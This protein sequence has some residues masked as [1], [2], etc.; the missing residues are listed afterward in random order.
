MVKKK[1]MYL[2]IQCKQTD[3]PEVSLYAASASASLAIANKT[4]NKKNIITNGN[5]EDN[6]G[7]IEKQTIEY[8]NN[9]DAE[10]TCM[11]TE[12]EYNEYADRAELSYVESDDSDLA[13]DLTK[14][15][16]Y[17]DAPDTIVINRI[18]TNAN[19]V[20]VIE[21]GKRNYSSYETEY[22]PFEICT[23]STNVKNT[24]NAKG[25]RITADYIIEI[26][27]AVA[28]KSHLDIRARI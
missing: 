13:G 8:A 17:K 23:Y 6:A 9:T 27:G 2:D 25:G 4:F 28:E 5:E 24:M 26:K 22:M 12:A 1:K 19:T 7:E 20:L 16:F 3:Y 10:N 11:T 15:I 21:K 18:G 14:V